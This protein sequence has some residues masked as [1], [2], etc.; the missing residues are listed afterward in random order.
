MQPGKR[1]HIF[2]DLRWMIPGYTGGLEVM[3]R[4]FLAELIKLD[5]SHHYTIL[6]PAVAR[7]DFDLAGGDNF[8]LVTCDGPGYY[9]AKIGYLVRKAWAQ[10]RGQPMPGVWVHARRTTAQV[11]LS[12]SG[13]I[14]PDLY[15]LKNVLA[16]HDIQHEYFPQFFD[17]HELAGR[18]ND[19]RAS[20]QHADR[21]ITVSEFTRQSLIHKL[22]FPPEIIRL[23]YEGV[24]PIFVPG[25]AGV[26]SITKDEDAEILARYGLQPG[27]Y[28]YYPANTWPHKN[29]LALLEALKILNDTYKLKPVLACTGTPKEAHPAI[30][31]T[32]E[33]YGLEEQ[34]CYLGYCPYNEL[35]ALYRGASMLVFPSLFEGFGL[36]IVEAMACGC[37]VVCSNTT[38]LPEVAGQ[39]ARYFDPNDASAMA[40]AIYTVISNHDLRKI[41]I[42][43]GLQQASRYTWNSYTQQIMRSL[44]DLAPDSNRDPISVTLPMRVKPLSQR[45][46]H[47]RQLVNAAQEAIRQKKPARGLWHYLQASFIAPEV[48]FTTVTFPWFR[49]RILRK[50]FA[51]FERRSAR[52]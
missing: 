13:T 21:I 27:E 9:L 50:I 32:V 31:K 5:D 43:D 25:G 6:L 35:P 48:V 17:Q 39:V 2:I 20:L 10:A 19:L 46:G 49:D 42:K 18:Q 3:A 30:L 47:S 45:I 14:S 33:Q 36:P 4:N 52:R 11:A 38:S 24:N 34:F 44:L 28:L 26:A 12:L 41:M 22:G 16:V 1:T 8:N 51:W 40:Q 29:H 7:Y 23:A 15:P 37:P